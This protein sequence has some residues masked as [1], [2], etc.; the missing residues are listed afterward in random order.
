[1]PKTNLKRFEI[2]NLEP[3]TLEKLN[4]IRKLLGLSQAKTLETIIEFYLS[5]NKDKLL[6]EFFK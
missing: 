4:K 1:M 2:R 3:K 6:K 5:K